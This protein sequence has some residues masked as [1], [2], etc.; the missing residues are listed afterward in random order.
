MEYSP[1][2]I[3]GA[4]NAPFAPVCPVRTCPLPACISVTFPAGMKAPE[5]SWTSTLMVPVETWACMA[6]DTERRITAAVAVTVRL[7]EIRTHSFGGDV[8]AQ[9]E[10]GSHYT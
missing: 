6:Q 10:P 5:E 3:N 9:T 2:G 4:R 7:R 1:T 8:T